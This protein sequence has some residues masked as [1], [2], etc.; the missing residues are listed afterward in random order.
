MNKAD[1]FFSETGF[2]PF[3]CLSV[4]V[5]YEKKT[6]WYRCY[7]M[8]Q[9]VIQQFQTLSVCE[10]LHL[11]KDGRANRVVQEVA[12]IHSTTWIVSAIGES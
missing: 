4:C 11:N 5:Y 12:Y 9:C 6:G 7:L 1:L 2:F 10:T 8:D 3:F